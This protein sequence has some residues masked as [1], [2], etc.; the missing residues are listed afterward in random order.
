MSLAEGVSQSLRYKSYSTGAITANS[1]PLASSDPGATGGQILRRVATTLSLAKNTYESAEIRTD[2]QRA[3][4]RHGTRHVQGN[5]TGELSPASYFDFF[6]AVH[7]D[8][9]VS[10]VTLTESDLTS[11]T[12]SNSGST[13][14]FGGGDPVALGLHVGDIIRFTNLS[15]SADDNVNF[16]I[17]G[18]SGGSNRVVAVTPAPTDQTA[19]VAFT[20]TRPGCTTI[21]PTS[22]HVSRKF[23]IEHY[24]ADLDL[25]RLFTECRATS[26]RLSMPATGMSTCE[27][28][29][30]GRDMQIL[31]GASAP[32]FT[33]PTAALTTGLCA[34]VNGA[35]L[36]AGTSLGVVTGVDL[37]MDL[38]PTAAD[39]LG[40]NFPGEIFLG[41]AAVSGTVTAYFDSATLIND[42]VNETEVSLQV[43]LNTTSAANTPAISIFLPRIKF[44]DA[45]VN[46]Q[47]EG[48]Q[49]ISL[50]FTALLADGTVTG[51][52]QSTIYICDTEAT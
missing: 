38:S 3:D 30:M 43:L 34:S 28:G 15:V 51:V 49:T 9:K 19:D 10:A 27:F 40:Q 4:F 7:R 44:G 37:T 1:E 5:I 8:T 36:V 14:T 13:W 35:L 45:A 22:G 47:G 23:G 26:Y 16:L 33:A 6:E 11:A 52:K 41:R 20:L 46:L 17:T 21:V 50:P 31:T 32:F 24:A 12:G 29:F 2:R 39:V 42:F 48:G 18:F 25:T